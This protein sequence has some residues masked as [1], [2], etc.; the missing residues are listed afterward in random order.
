MAPGYIPDSIHYTILIPWKPDSPFHSQVA[1]LEGRVQDLNLM[2]DSRRATRLEPLTNLQE[3]FPQQ[4]PSKLVHVV[5]QLPSSRSLLE[6]GLGPPQ[7]EAEHE[8]DTFDDLIEHLAATPFVQDAP[9]AVS[10]ASVFRRCQETTERILNDRPNKDVKVPPIA[11]LYSPFGQ[12]I[13]HFRDLPEKQEPGVDLW[14]FQLAV[15]VFASQMCK[16]FTDESERQRTIL[17]LLNSIFGCYGPFRLP[18]ITANRI[19][20]D[21]TSDGHANGPADVMETVV[22]FK[23]EFG[24]TRS[25][26]EIQLTSYYLQMHNYQIRFGRHK[27]C[28]QK[29]LCPTLG[30]SVIGIE[31]RVSY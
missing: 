28:F 11:L 20:G 22:E 17:P 8:R 15:D 14:K 29:N 24:S 23:N 26:P 18:Q 31:T 1:G 19:A 21:I 3:Y 4:P 25:D 5:V 27:E 10:V 13:D 2:E 12:F 7:V 9:S 30:I 16:H 6:P